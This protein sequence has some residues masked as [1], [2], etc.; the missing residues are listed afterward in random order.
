MSFS[1]A[2]RTFWVLALLGALHPAYARAD[3]A[4]PSATN[5]AVTDCEGNWKVGAVAS[6]STGTPNIRI[7]FQDAQSG[8][9][10]GRQPF[11]G[12]ANV[13]GKTVLLMHFDD[14][15]TDDSAWGNDG[16][17]STAPVYSYLDVPEVGFSSAAV[18]TGA[19]GER[20]VRINASP[21]LAST[22][23]QFTI[24]AWINPDDLASAPIFEWNNGTVAG[25]RLWHGQPNN[26]G[27]LYAAIV[28]SGANVQILQAEANIISSD[29]WQ[30]VTLTYHNTSRIATFYLNDVMVASITMNSFPFTL[31]TSYDVYIGSRPSGAGVAYSGLIDEVRVT[32]AALD[33]TDVLN[34]YHSGVFQY[35]LTGAAGPHT[36]V[37]LASGT[38]GNY[39]SNPAQGRTLL[40]TATVMQLAISPTGNN[41]LRFYTQDRAGNTGAGSIST[42]GMDIQPP[43]APTGLTGTRISPQDVDLSWTGSEEAFQVY[44]STTP[45]HVLDP[46]NLLLPDTATCAHTDDGALTSQSPN[47]F[48]KIVPR[49]QVATADSELPKRRREQ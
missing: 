1:R 46:V 2:H 45:D 38:G 18:F 17:S 42:L 30:L 24:Q 39:P 47:W 31:R 3:S 20:F 7:D 15:M 40:T 10:F 21:S 16:T 48:Y 8:L 36:T 22:T 5:L 28:D 14:D 35:S 4:P 41:S 32:T 13:H 37:Y 34:N 26:S 29:T 6:T 12:G 44:R 49:P 23:D 27:E 9:K 11:A 25:V 33:S 43:G 19:A